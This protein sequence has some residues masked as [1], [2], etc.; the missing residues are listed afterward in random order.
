MSVQGE[1]NKMRYHV[2]TSVKAEIADRW[3]TLKT[4]GW[5]FNEVF[6]L[7][8]ENAEKKEKVKHA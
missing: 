4:Q 8:I 3:I 1:K 6:I 2:G 7:G 5:K